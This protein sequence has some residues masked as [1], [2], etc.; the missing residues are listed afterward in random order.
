MSR[1][2]KLRTLLFRLGSFALGLGLLYLALRGADLRVIWEDLKQADYRWLAPLVLLTLLS[3]VIRAWRWRLLLEALPDAN[4]RR[5]LTVARAFQALMIGYMVN[6]A[7]PRLGELAR[8]ASLSRITGLRLSS[9][10]G[11]VVAERLLDLL[12]LA[13]ALLSVLVMLL[14]RWVELH[15]LF[16]A[17]WL[18]SG[19]L[20][21]LAGGALLV[22]L[23]LGLGVYLG[24]RTPLLRRVGRRLH[25]PL[26]AFKH[27]LFTVHRTPRPVALTL[28]TLLMWACYWGMAYLPLVMLHL[29]Q[30]YGLGPAEAWVLLVLGAVGVALPSPGGLGSYHYITVQV[31]VHLLAVPQAPAATYAVLTHGAQMVLYTLIGFICLVLQGGH[32]RPPDDTGL[33]ALPATFRTPSTSP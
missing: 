29:S 11:T 23:F 1:T 12:V 6:Y 17:P 28:S 30:P 21:L 22:L 25:G 27:G 7:A 20:Q 3:H 2:E 15:R 19:S 24:R 5:R 32:W 10:L 13:L 18:Q 9:V 33:E 14:D 4:G 26:A 8:A 31:M 16:V